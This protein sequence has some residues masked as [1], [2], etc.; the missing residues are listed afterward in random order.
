MNY[1]DLGLLLVVALFGYRGSL[2]GGCRSFVSLL[3]SILAIALAV[4][5][6]VQLLPLL[7]AAPLSNSLRRIF[8][9]GISVP[10]GPGFTLDQA[11]QWLRDLELPQALADAVQSSWLRD[12]SADVAAFSQAASHILAKAVLNMMCF[13]VLFIVMRWMINILSRALIRALPLE[14]SQSARS[15]GV[16]LGIIESII[17]SAVIVAILAPFVATTMVPE[18]LIEYYK[19]S[20]LVGVTLVLLKWVG[21]VFYGV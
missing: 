2:R 13:L 4:F 12:S 11:L 6:Q 1:L 7:A 9:V 8:E 5:C 15:L 17:I 20:K 19:T 18:S 14:V 21:S 10:T 16:S 3:Q